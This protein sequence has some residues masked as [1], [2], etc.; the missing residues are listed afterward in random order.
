MDY[1]KKRGSL[2][3][4]TTAVTS[5]TASDVKDNIITAT[6]YRKDALVTKDVDIVNLAID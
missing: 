2:N 4:N 3:L 6:D 5:E 1:S